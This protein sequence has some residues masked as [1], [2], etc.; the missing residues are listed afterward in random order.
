MESAFIG[1][2]HVERVLQ[3]NPDWGFRIVNGKIIPSLEAVQRDYA[4]PKTRAGVVK[5]LLLH[6][7]FGF[8]EVNGTITEVEF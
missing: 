6:P 2:A 7:E 3:Q 8:E 1:K 5:L 4:D